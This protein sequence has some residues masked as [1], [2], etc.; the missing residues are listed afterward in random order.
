MIKCTSS[1]LHDRVQ[2]RGPVARRDAPHLPNKKS[3]CKGSIKMDISRGRTEAA[4]SYKSRQVLM[5]KQIR[6]ASVAHTL[7][8]KVVEG[9]NGDRILGALYGDMA[10]A[11][12]VVQRVPD[13]ALA[14]ASSS[15]RN[16]AFSV[17]AVHS[18]F[19]WACRDLLTD[20]LEFWESDWDLALDGVKPPP[21]N[22]DPLTKR[23]WLGTITEALRSHS[24]EEGYLHSCYSL[25][26]IKPNEQ[27]IAQLPLFDFFRRCR[28]RIIHQDGTA[29]S[30]LVEFSKSK[31]LENAY[32]SLT[33]SVKRMAPS[34]P[35]LYATDAIVLSPQHA[36]LFMLVARNL[37][38][39]LAVRIRSQLSEDGYFRMA[40]YYAYVPV[41]HPFRSKTYNNV[42]HPA[43]H[44]LL[45]RYHVTGLGKE[46]LI[47]RFRSLNLWDAMVARYHELFPQS[48]ARPKR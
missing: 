10:H 18:D 20:A 13:A 29:G 33:S 16:V 4:E 44:F 37:F 6:I 27:D 3:N 45:Y 40:A 12:R 1:P 28:N 7:L 22:G 46:G 14:V 39:A 25:I 34:L 2:R 32:K 41:S 36:I 19:E 8:S 21:A 26:G 9:Q 42:V 15:R 5:D 47:R 43:S 38:R 24:A 17:A 11:S 31:E 35:K 30:D 23:G 48:L